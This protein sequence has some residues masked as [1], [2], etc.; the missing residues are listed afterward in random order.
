MKNYMEE[1]AKLLGVKFGEEFE[2]GLCR[3]KYVLTKDG[4]FSVNTNKVSTGMLMCILNGT[5]EI[6]HKP[7]KPKWNEDYYHINEIGNVV[8]DTWDE[9]DVDIMLYKLGNCYRTMAEAEANRNKWVSF[10]ASDKVLEV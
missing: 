3:V 8:I 4:L 6:N 7:W 5:T 2:V 9:L 10:Y 1:V